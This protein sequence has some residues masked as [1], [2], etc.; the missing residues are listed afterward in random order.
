MPGTRN[1]PRLLTA[2]TIVGDR[3]KNAAGDDLGSI[4]EL[5]IDTRSGNIAYAV[6]SFGGF[7]G[8]GNK[9]F[10]VPWRALQLNPVDRTFVLD[11]DRERLEKA[12]GFDRDSWPDMADERWSAGIQAYWDDRSP[13]R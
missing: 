13:R 7:L 1:T 4:D 5:M 6:L 2:G 10:A 3:V 8:I 12:P 11:V 9:L